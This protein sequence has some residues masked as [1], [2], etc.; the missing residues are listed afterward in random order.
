MSQ[1]PVNLESKL[2]ALAIGNNVD[3]YSEMVKDMRLK[4]EAGSFKK[5]WM[6]VKRECT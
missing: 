5:G 6:R 3:V 4:S 1:T 2:P